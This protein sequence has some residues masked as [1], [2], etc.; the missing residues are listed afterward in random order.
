MLQL[1]FLVFQLLPL[2]SGNKGHTIQ[3]LNLFKSK[4]IKLDLK[5]GYFKLPFG[6]YLE[7]TQFLLN[8]ILMQ[9]T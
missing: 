4:S 5:L 6:F 3:S 2:L 1:Q 9:L 8:S 7:L